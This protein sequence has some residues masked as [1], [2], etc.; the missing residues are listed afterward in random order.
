MLGIIN[1]K[2]VLRH[3]ALMGKLSTRHQKL[4]LAIKILSVKHSRI[5]AS[6]RILMLIYGGFC[7]Q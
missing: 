5:I 6:S 3:R 2:E 7:T 4:I 1:A